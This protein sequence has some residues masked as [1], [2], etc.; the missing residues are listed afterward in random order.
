MKKILCI[1]DI[2]EEQIADGVQ[3]KNC[4]EELFSRKYSLVMEA[5]PETAINM[6]GQDQSIKLI[7]LD[8]MFHGRVRGPEIAGRIFD[9]NPN[10]PII[11]LTKE[12]FHGGEGGR[13]LVYMDNIWK[14]IEKKVFAEPKKK[15][16]IINLTEC[17]IEDPINKN[18]SILIMD[19]EKLILHH[20]QSE[21][22]YTISIPNKI[23]DICIGL[24][25]EL[26][27]IA[28]R[29][30]FDFNN[31]DRALIKG[32]ENKY[33][34]GTAVTSLATIKYELNKLV[35]EATSWRI[36]ELLSTRGCG[37]G[38]VKLMAENEDSLQAPKPVSV[39]SADALTI[40]QDEVARLKE[41]MAK[42][43]AHLQI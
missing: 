10:V 19:E 15:Q 40:L 14:Y 11:V 25:D 3:L 31:I 35:Y 36:C 26:L 1:D 17:L 28:P 41:R 32:I 16:K 24:F 21:L 4:L 18:W 43:E 20:L 9:I 22:E 39:R 2:P 23:R 8:V 30:P 6:I 13:E 37:K 12:P 42:I 38:K 34:K 33:E 27:S 5:D 7:L 29:T